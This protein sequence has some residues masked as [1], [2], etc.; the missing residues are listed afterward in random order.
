MTI[1][2]GEPLLFRGEPCTTLAQTLLLQDE[3]LIPRSESYCPILKGQS[4]DIL[5]LL[6]YIDR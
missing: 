2:Y 1:L 3:Y 6:F 5:I 4:S